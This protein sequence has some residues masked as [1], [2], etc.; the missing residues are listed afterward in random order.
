MKK[1][2]LYRSIILILFV[3][4]CVN[5]ANAGLVDTKTG[6]PI[7]QPPVNVIAP[8]T[9][10]NPNPLWLK[11]T[12]NNGWNGGYISSIGA[13]GSNYYGQS[14]ISTFTSISKFGV[15]IRQGVAVGQLK[16]A[17]VADNHGK[18]DYASPLYEGTVI[19]PTTTGQWYFEE[20]LDIP[21]VPGQKYYVLIDGYNIPGSTG[22]DYIGLSDTCPISGEGIVWA[23]SGDFVHWYT[24][25][26]Y[27]LAIYIDGIPA[28]VPVPYW[29]IILAFVV[30]G[31]SAF[32]AYKRKL[33]KSAA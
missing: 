21:V 15:V 33:A 28:P 12:I 1:S 19:T 24:Y 13:S 6:H 14:F 18:P 16:I 22:W 4:A 9:Y 31:G 20:G 11:A 27:P 5:N 10:V 17:I 8:P 32:Y 29:A 26:S 25:S 3:I 30:I 23:N 2:K 7:V